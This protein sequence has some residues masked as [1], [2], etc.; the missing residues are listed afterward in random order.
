MNRTTLLSRL[1]PLIERGLIARA[2]TPWQILQGNV[3]M[4]PYVVIPDA[5]DRRRYAGAPLGHPIVRTPFLVTYTFGGHFSVGSGLSSSE[6]SLQ[7]HL[8]AVY[9]NGQPVYDLQLAQ[10][11]P[12][13]LERMRSRFL[14]VRDAPS[15]A[16]RI[17]RALV[18]AIVPSWHDYC[19]AML[20]HIDRAARFDY[21]SA[22]DWCP[23]RFWSFAA[24]MNHCAL[25][26]PPFFRGE[27]PL[28]LTRRLF[29][30][31]TGKW[32]DTPR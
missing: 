25:S 3:E 26:F 20:G 13:G 4:L 1:S 22:P 11:F 9:H 24:F 10:T 27:N 31:F 23:E 6:A 5:D 30:L 16:L 8:L 29:R 7:K 18:G 28:A 2:P 12:D 21:D 17:E 15:R 32:R 19:T 14:A